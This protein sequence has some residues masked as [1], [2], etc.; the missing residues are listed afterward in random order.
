MCKITSKNLHLQ[1]KFVK[2]CYGSVRIQKEESL[3]SIPLE[4]IW[5]LLPNRYQYTYTSEKLISRLRLPCVCH[6]KHILQGKHDKKSIT[7][8]ESCKLH[9]L[10][11][12]CE[13]EGLFEMSQCYLIRGHFKVFSRPKKS[14]KYFESLH[15]LS[16][17]NHLVL[18]WLVIPSHWLLLLSLCWL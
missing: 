1:I 5:P 15:N 13:C 17:S 6:E 4:A 16:K 7:Q 8:G 14:I 3:S 10:R 11:R 9:P 18:S 12:Q 2:I